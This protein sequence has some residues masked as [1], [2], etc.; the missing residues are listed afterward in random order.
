MQFCSVVR[1][2]LYELPGGITI[3]IPMASSKQAKAYPYHSGQ[4]VAVTYL[5]CQ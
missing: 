1:T 5:S 2:A 3:K 4:N